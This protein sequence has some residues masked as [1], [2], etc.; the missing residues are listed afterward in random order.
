MTCLRIRRGLFDHGRRP[1][2]RG[3]DRRAHHRDRR[4]AG[5]GRARGG[6]AARASR[7]A[8]DRSHLPT[9]PPASHRGAARARDRGRGPDRLEVERPDGTRTV[10]TVEPMPFA[11]YAAWARRSRDAAAPGRPTAS[12]PGRPVPLDVELLDDGVALCPLSRPSQ[13]R[14]GGRMA[15]DLIDAGSVRRLVLDLRQNPGGDNTTTGRCSSSVGDFAARHPGELRVLIDRVTFSAAAN[16][17]TDIERRTDAVFVGEPMGGGLN[18]WDDVAFVRLDHLPVPMHGRRQHALLGV[19]R[20]R[21]SAPD[22]RARRADAG[23]RRGLLRRHR[24]RS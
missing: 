17:A 1:A 13:P 4:D 7:R 21:R 12:L 2:E 10:E 22:D 19:R 16:L 8:G 24:S 14:V 5:R 20:S 18:F 11:D 6:R 3:P 23:E 9:G 15:R